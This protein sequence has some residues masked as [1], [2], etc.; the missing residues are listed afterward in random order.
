MLSELLNTL[1]PFL[2][3]FGDRVWIQAL[4]VIAGSFLIAWIFNR[5]IISTLK[6]LTSKT[7]ISFDNQLVELLHTPI[8]TT[9]ILIGLALATNM[10][11]IADFAEFLIFSSL[12]TVA[13]IIWTLFLLR[14]TKI[15]LRHIARNERHIGILHPQ[16]LPLFEN[17]A[18]ITIFVFAIY[19]IFT[20]WDVDM[21]AWLASA[22]IV[23]IAVGFAA[24]DT[25][26]NLFSGVFILADAPYKIGDFVVLDSGERG[27][28]T[29]IGIR[30]TR[31]LTRDDIEITVPNSIMGN[32]KVLNESGGP[33][34]RHRIRIAVGVAYGSDIDKVRDILMNIAID[35]IDVC[36]DPEPRVRFRAFGASSLDF[37]LLCWI[38]QPVLRGRMIDT[39]NCKVYKRFIEEKIEIPYSKHDLYIKEMP[40][41]GE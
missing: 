14:I 38:D 41:T 29:H 22:G 27:E 19:I 35:D 18:N 34:A 33:G 6:K 39:L 30:S 1:R 28:I 8:F 2:A 32:T 25:L 24:K 9:V 26:A 10:L 23:G 17:I 12:R 15:V 20:A 7:S 11:Q 3:Y 16:T 37:E 4:V 13:Y 31:L 40:G 36:E 21:T 5:F